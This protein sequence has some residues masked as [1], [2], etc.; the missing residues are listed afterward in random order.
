[1]VA[2]G[3]GETD[4]GDDSAEVAVIGA[5]APDTGSA[6]EVGTAQAQLGVSDT[7]AGTDTGAAVVQRALGE[8]GVG[9]DTVAVFVAVPTGDA[10]A[11]TD[12]TGMGVEAS[13]AETGSEAALSELAGILVSP[14][15]LV[16]VVPPAYRVAR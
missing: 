2:T 5:R 16:Y 9:A 7:G 10:A 6:A 12:T 1:V 8:T 14:D 4:I 15:I 11:A 3:M 13:D